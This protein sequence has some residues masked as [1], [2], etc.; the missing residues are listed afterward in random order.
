ML[1]FIVP[2]FSEKC[3]KVFAHND[4]AVDLATNP[5]SSASTNNI[6]VRFHLIRELVKS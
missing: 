6:D 2:S 4:G 1:P 5:L 3:L